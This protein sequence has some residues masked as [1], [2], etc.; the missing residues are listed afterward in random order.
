MTEIEIMQRAK[1]YID[2]LANGIDPLTDQPVPEGDTINNVR[3]SRCLFYVSDVL[4][5]VIENG[6]HV[7]RTRKTDKIPFS[8]TREVLQD[9]QFSDKPISVSDI[10]R[11]INALVDTETMAKMKYSAITGFLTNCGFLEQRDNEFGKKTRFPTNEGF[12]LG[13]LDIEGMKKRISEW[14]NLYL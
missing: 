13:I 1:M 5:Q 4:R 14:A 12:A 6:G 2:K 10:T 8:V 7:K 11:R 3:I 9:F